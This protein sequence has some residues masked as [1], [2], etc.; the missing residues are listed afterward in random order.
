VYGWDEKGILK[1]H[2]GRS[3]GIIG[4]TVIMHCDGVGFL[5]RQGGENHL[6]IN[7]QRHY[8]VN[9]GLGNRNWDSMY[10]R[11]KEMVRYFELILSIYTSEPFPAVLV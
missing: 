6:C 9:T 3:G 1:L 2:L 5:D 10:Q 11:N 4:R 7:H 8:F